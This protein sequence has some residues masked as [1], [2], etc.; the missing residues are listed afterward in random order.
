MP[1]ASVALLSGGGWL[2]LDHSYYKDF[3]ERA[4]PVQVG[5]GLVADDE[6]VVF[7]W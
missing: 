1:V 2:L 5:C 3:R 4:W 7:L 6:D